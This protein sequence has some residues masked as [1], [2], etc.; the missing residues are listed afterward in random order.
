MREICQVDELD[1]MY[2]PKFT[3]TRSIPP[4]CGSKRELQDLIYLLG[5]HFRPAIPESYSR[6]ARKNILPPF[7]NGG[8]AQHGETTEQIFSTDD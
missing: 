1:E 4:S 3:L 6:K 7:L 8:G 5:I 2:G